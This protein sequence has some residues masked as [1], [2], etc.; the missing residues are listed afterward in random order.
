MEIKKV[1]ACRITCDADHRYYF[2][3]ANGA[4]LET[5]TSV[6]RILNPSVPDMAH[7]KAAADYGTEVHSIVEAEIERSFHGKNAADIICYDGVSNVGKSAESILRKVRDLLSHP[8][9]TRYPVARKDQEPKTVIHE[10]FCSAGCIGRVD[11]TTPER[12]KR[13][14][15]FGGTTDAICVSRFILGDRKSKKDFCKTVFEFKT[16]KKT[17]ND[18]LLQLAVYMFLVDADIGFVV[19]DNPSIENVVIYKEDL[20]F[21]LAEFELKA[22]RFF[23]PP[24]TL[25]SEKRKKLAELSTELCKISTQEKTLKA[26]RDALIQ[27]IVNGDFI[28][29]GNDIDCGDFKI[30]KQ[31]SKRSAVV[32]KDHFKAN[33]PKIYER[34]ILETSTSFMVVRKNSNI[35]EEVYHG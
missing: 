25:E 3:M 26:Q 16:T 8:R 18:H 21:Y 6:T 32:D 5:T 14:D 28:Y 9:L 27:E 1:N 23:L 17:S 19:Y 35:N 31:I 2:E 20:E 34:Y 22:A 24:H 4:G 7:I 10:F 11:Y 15:Y 33:H 12:T 30:Q 29:E 13:T